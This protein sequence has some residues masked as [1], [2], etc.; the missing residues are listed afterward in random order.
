M[1]ANLNQPMSF[2][3]VLENFDGEGGRGTSLAA[4]QTAVEF[5]EFAQSSGLPAPVWFPTPEGEI[6]LMFAVN[7]IVVTC[8]NEK[9]V[10][11]Y[12]VEWPGF[13]QNRWKTV[14]EEIKARIDAAPECSRLTALGSEGPVQLMGQLE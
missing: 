9:M 13:E 6:D 10:L 7:T 14:V 11:P 5:V 4:Y 2:A 12:W 1:S 8:T 3:P